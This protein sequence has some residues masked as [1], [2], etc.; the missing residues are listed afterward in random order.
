MTSAASRFLGEPQTR[1]KLVV[2]VLA[3][4]AIGLTA[5]RLPM[6]AEAQA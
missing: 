1:S 3:G 6:L 4:L 2:A 5:S